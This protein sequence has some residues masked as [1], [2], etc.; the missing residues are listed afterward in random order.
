LHFVIAVGLTTT[1]AQAY[2]AQAGLVAAIESARFVGGDQVGHL[3]AEGRANAL[4]II[5]HLCDHAVLR[6]IN[7]QLRSKV[8]GGCVA[9]VSALTVADSARN[10]ADLRIFLSY[11]EHGPET[12][13]FRS[14]L[15]LML[16]WTGE[17]PSPWAQE[18]QLWL[19]LKG[20]RE[21]PVPLE[22]RLKWL[23]ETASASSELFLP[24]EREELAIAP[25]FVLLDTSN[26]IQA[27]SQADVYAV[28]CNALATARCDN[29]G[30]DAKTQRANPTPVWGQSVFGQCVLCPSNFRDFNDAVLRASLLRAASIQEL[31]YSVDEVCSEEMRDVIR[32]DISSW[33]QGRGDALTEFLLSMACGRLRLVRRHVDQIKAD[34]NVAP[35]PEHLKFLALN[36]TVP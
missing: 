16:P 33:S 20:D 10:L 35:L 4:V 23:Q 9:Y 11:G 19:R 21:L 24:G 36:I 30:L 7:A 28:V 22:K 34:I 1:D 2:C 13:I 12:Y 5:G 6:G 18:L 32:A 8:G 17:Q 26:N 31:N 29:Q 27:I 25:D 14:A 3:P 15:E